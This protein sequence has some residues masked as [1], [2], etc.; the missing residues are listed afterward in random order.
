MINI[1]TKGD[2]LI[3]LLGGID[4]KLL[5]RQKMSLIE[6]HAKLN[7]MEQEYDDLE[8]ILNLLD[9]ISDFMEDNPDEVGRFRV[10]RKTRLMEEGKI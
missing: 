4:L 2:L 9:V 3:E 1:K 7:G 6:V 5:K 10:K 8:G